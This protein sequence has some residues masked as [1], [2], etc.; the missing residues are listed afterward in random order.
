MKYRNRRTGRVIDIGSVLTGK[1]WE[2]LG[3]APAAAPETKAELT[4]D[5]GKTTKAPAKKPAKTAAKKQNAASESEYA[6]VKPR[7]SAAKTT[8]GNKK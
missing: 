7:G 2:P 3:A 1:D 6:S 4:A 8:K 5:A